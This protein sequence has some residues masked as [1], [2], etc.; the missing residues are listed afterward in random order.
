M[1][2]SFA[3]ADGRALPAELALAGECGQLVDGGGMVQF[4]EQI[5]TINVRIEVPDLLSP[6]SPQW[7]DPHLYSGQGIADGEHK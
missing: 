7:S 6:L 2:I 5:Q 1:D 3:M 4:N